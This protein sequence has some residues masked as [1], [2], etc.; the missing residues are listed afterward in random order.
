MKKF[1]TACLAAAC[2]LLAIFAVYCIIS[3][4]RR[5]HAFEQPPLTREELDRL[6]Q[7]AKPAQAPAPDPILTANAPVVSAAEP[8]PDSAALP[9]RLT[10]TLTDEQ[11]RHWIVQGRIRRLLSHF[12]MSPVG[13]AIQAIMSH[14][15]SKQAELY[16]C[17]QMFLGDGNF[18]RAKSCF[19]E[20]VRKDP[21]GWAS[22]YAYAYLAHI[23]DD[24]EMAARYME[25][26]SASAGDDPWPLLFCRNLARDTGSN[27]L[28]AYYGRLYEEKF[29][30]QQPGIEPPR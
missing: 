29:R 17:G 27:E 15:Y 30:R 9:R 16:F 18:A 1:K 6:S 22:A 7:N 3:T 14:P 13:M 5:Q 25:L 8:P 12:Q 20:M 28:A 21:D 24:P 26:A 10:R 2:V 11:R 23:E 4:L 19:S